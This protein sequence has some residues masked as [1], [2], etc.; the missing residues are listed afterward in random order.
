MTMLARGAL[1]ASI[2]MAALPYLAAL[3]PVVAAE[4]LQRVLAGMDTGAARGEAPP[5][6]RVFRADVPVNDVRSSND[7]ARR[8]GMSALAWFGHA[9]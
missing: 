5:T 1:E 2:C 4:G 3:P 9:R 6:C 8:G 7:S